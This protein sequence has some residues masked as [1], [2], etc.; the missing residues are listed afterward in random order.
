[1]SPSQHGRKFVRITHAFASF[2]PQIPSC[3]LDYKQSYEVVATHSNQ[4]SESILNMSKKFV[5]DAEGKFLGYKY[6][7][8]YAKDMP[9]LPMPWEEPLQCYV[10]SSPDVSLI[11]PLQ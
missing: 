11:H 1:M 10:I 4:C 3:V 7:I 6:A 8:A 5:F 9:P 2:E